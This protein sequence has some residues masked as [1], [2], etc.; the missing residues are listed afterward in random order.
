MWGFAFEIAQVTVLLLFV[1]SFSVN[2]YAAL[3]LP[4]TVALFQLRSAEGS[5]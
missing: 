1:N 2:A 3:H 4:A 5:R